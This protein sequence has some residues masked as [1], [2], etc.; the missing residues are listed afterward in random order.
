MRCMDWGVL[1]DIRAVLREF[2][3]DRKQNG[4]KFNLKEFYEWIKEETWTDK[5]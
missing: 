3:E 5:D 1:R 2:E 4:G